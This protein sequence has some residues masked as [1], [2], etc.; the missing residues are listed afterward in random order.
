MGKMNRFRTA[1]IAGFTAILVTASLGQD[2]E[3]I[4]TKAQEEISAKNYGSARQK[5]QTILQHNNAYA[6][7]YF[8]LSKI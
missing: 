4:L 8:E 3:E 1:L 5:L 6:P 7:A 2:L